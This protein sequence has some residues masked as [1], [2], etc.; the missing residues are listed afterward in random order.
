M[1]K[2][3]RYHLIG[4]RASIIRGSEMHIFRSTDTCTIH[5]LLMLG[6]PFLM[7][8]HPPG[9]SSL[10]SLYT[11]PFEACTP[12]FDAPTPFFDARTV[13]GVQPLLSSYLPPPPGILLFWCTPSPL[14]PAHPILI[15]LRSVLMP[16]P[17]PP[18]RISN[19]QSLNLD[20]I[21]KPFER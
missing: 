11:N 6:L 9:I 18:P 13:Y 4:S 14:M 15:H 8:T 20:A 3:T 12:L 2:K 17:P 5:P 1:S 7:P 19:S 21:C 10:L 16:V